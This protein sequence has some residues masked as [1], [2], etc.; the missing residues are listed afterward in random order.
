MW[1][2]LHYIKSHVWAATIEAYKVY[3][4]ALVPSF[5]LQAERPVWATVLH[6]NNTILLTKQM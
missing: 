5:M 3:I 6:K 1:S 4:N 2:V